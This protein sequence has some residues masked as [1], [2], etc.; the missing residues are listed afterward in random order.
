MQNGMQNTFIIHAKK[1]VFRSGD[2]RIG[3]LGGPGT[4]KYRHLR[5]VYIYIR[6]MEVKLRSKW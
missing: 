6:Q 2:A 1:E 5:S 3:G 4:P